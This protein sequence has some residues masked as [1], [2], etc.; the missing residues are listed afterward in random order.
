M[1]GFLALHQKT[2][3]GKA[4]LFI[5]NVVQAAIKNGLRVHGVKVSEQPFLDIGTWDDLGR[6][7]SLPLDK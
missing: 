5:G 6:T 7:T 4:E 1:H 2:A 3:A